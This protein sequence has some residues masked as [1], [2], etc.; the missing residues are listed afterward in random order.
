[1]QRVAI[2]T[3][4]TACLPRELA[5]G[6]GIRVAPFS[7]LFGE[8][9]YRDDE[10][11]QPQ[12]F[13]RLLKEHLEPPKTSPASPGTY[14]DIFREVGQSFPSILCVT[15]HAGLSSLY[16]AAW[17]AREMAREAFPETEIAIL[18]SQSASMAAGFIVLEAA[19]SAAEGCDLGQVLEVAEKVKP[20]VRLIA[21]LDTLEYLARSRRIP[22]VGAWAASLLNMK[23]IL[24]ITGGE[25]RRLTPA[26]SKNGALDKILKRVRKE[27]RPGAQLHAA[28]IH[29]NA[30]QEATAFKERLAAALQCRELYL[31]PFTP[32]MGMYT[33]PGLVG[34]AY[35]LEDP[36]V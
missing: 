13:Y 28:I 15:L 33:G 8:V 3:D 20:K 36:R 17:S 26:L 34:V 4:S 7:F 29:T 21:V 32:V 12:T 24:N 9:I 1:M 22:K 27:A 10:R 6:Y 19:R 31:A 5:E 23:P 30:E 16:N 25:V 14:L 18:D 35:Y 11:S 2:V